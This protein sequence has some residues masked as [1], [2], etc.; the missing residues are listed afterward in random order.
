MTATKPYAAPRQSAAT[1]TDADFTYV[2][3]P[4]IQNIDGVEKVTGRARYVGDMTVPGMLFARVLRSP[5]PH[6]RIVELDVAPAL[7]IPGVRAAITHRDFVEDGAFGYP[8]RDAYI[9]ACHKV[10]YV[11]DPVAAVA[12]D[13][14]EAARA[15]LEAI[16]V[17]YE[18][19]PVIGDMGQAL[20]DGAP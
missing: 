9:L 15:A 2:G 17:V 20:D 12:A 11:G 18:P 19:L 14:P 5:L 10:R 3:N 8:V 7:A 16:R 4:S 1:R 6:A 13:T